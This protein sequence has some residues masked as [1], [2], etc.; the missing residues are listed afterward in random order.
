M[1]GKT[2]TKKLEVEQKVRDA[3]TLAISGMKQEDIARELAVNE[4]TIRRYV[5][6]MRKLRVELFRKASDWAISQVMGM[7]EQQMAVLAQ[8]EAQGQTEKKWDQVLAVQRQKLELLRQTIKM[9]QDLG[10]VQQSPVQLEQKVNI[11]FNVKRPGAPSN[12]GNKSGD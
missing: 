5:E 3:Y 1:A 9:L 7:F 8:L 4:R 12:A 6:K 2:G 10:E 11:V